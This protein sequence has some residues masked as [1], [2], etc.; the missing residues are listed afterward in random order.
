MEFAKVVERSSIRTRIE[1]VKAILPSYHN[2]REKSESGGLTFLFFE[3]IRT[4]KFHAMHY[5]FISLRETLVIYKGRQRHFFFDITFYRNNYFFILVIR[6]QVDVI[7]VMLNSIKNH[8]I[9]WRIYF[10]H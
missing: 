5:P 6:N 7:I 4:Y 10:G 8:F 3:N 2:K 1:C 9:I